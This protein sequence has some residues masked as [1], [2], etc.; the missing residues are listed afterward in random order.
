MGK[1]GRQPILVFA[2]KDRTMGLVVDEIVD[3]V[4]DRLQV[5]VAV[6]RPGLIGSADHRRQGDRPHR[7]RLS[8]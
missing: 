4:E 5:E 7:C 3:I 2:D 1:E 8:T 6:D